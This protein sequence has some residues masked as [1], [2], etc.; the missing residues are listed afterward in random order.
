MNI[1]K[2][3]PYFLPIIP[4]TLFFLFWEIFAEYGIINQSLFSKP[5]LILIKL[6]ELSSDLIK[7][8]LATL[9]RLMVSFT[10]A[11]IIGVSIGIAMGYKRFI[12]RFFNP[13]ITMIMTIPGIALAP[14]F[15]VWLGFGDPT[16][17]TIGIIVAFFPI[18]YNTSMG[19]RSIDSQ[20]IKA[21]EIM[22][23]KKR[24]LI[25]KIYLPHSLSYIIIGIK[26]GLARCWRTIIAVEFIAATNYG[27]GFMIW[28]SYE[29]LR[30]SIVYG[31]IILLAI[32]F[33]IIE[34][35]A[36]RELEK[37]TIEKWGVI[38]KHE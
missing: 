32:I 22:G 26:L 2:L 23:A 24:D 11:L 3:S 8:I 35:I 38:H 36:I 1:K 30:V 16:I 5:S 27:L 19:V 33:F 34:K 18:V 37:R 17:I 12:Y 14:I 6:Y 31:G 7:N 10:I 25:L 28:D 15:I 29:Y 9:Y 21:G 20:L 4:I 13:L